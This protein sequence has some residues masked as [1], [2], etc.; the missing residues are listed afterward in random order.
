VVSLSA[1]FRLQLGTLDLQAE[2]DVRAGELLAL[3]GPNGAG[4]STVLRCLAGLVPI[5]A[6]RIAL[7]GTVLDDPAANVF[8]GPEARS[9]GFV[10][11]NYVLFPHMTVLENVAYGLRARRTPK[12]EARRIA[13]NWIERV[14]LAEYAHQRPPVLSG[15][16][17]QRAALARVLATDPRLLLLDEPLAALDAGTRGSVRRDLRRHLATFD[18]IRILVTHDPVDAYALADRVAILDAGRIV[19]TGTLAEVTAHPRS[20]YVAD[21]VGVNLVAGTIAAGVLTTPGGAHVVIAEDMTGPSF[22]VIRPHSIV[23]V[24]DAPTGSSARNTWSGVV[25]DI[26]RLGERVRVGL[27]GALPLTAEITV[28]ALEALQL[29]PGDEIHASVKATDIEVYPA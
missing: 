22:A 14:G 26:D 21:L 2:L 13:G 3:L 1:S 18:G 16:Q 17:A 11:Q 20:R 29:R 10:F 15:G 19:Q 24:R 6:G 28:G 9:V 27:E 8:V 23:L 12:A 5:D 25:G 4:K 7:D